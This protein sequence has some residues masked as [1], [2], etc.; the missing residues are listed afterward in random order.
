MLSFENV[1]QSS[2]NK[3]VKKF[4]YISSINAFNRSPSKQ[5]LNESRELV[6]KG[7]SYDLTKALAQDLV[8]N[9][10]EI[11]SI[12]INPSGIIGKN[13]FKPSMF[14]NVLRSIYKNKMPFYIDAGANIIDV[15][16]LCECIYSSIFSHLLFDINLKDPMYN[17]FHSLGP[18]IERNKFLSPS[19]F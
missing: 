14:G 13:D 9:N 5:I 7:N 2:I 3:K 8:L 10:R 1:L 16:D 15:E 4:I 12:S 18:T 6:K 11:V 19:S 17:I